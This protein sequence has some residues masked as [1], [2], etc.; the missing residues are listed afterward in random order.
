MNGMKFMKKWHL[1]VSLIFLASIAIAG[2]NHN[3]ATEIGVSDDIDLQL[4]VIYENADIWQVSDEQVGDFC[5]SRDFK[6]YGYAISDL[7]EDGYL[8][9]IKSGWAGPGAL[10]T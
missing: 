1:A 3:T 8:E 2:C 6:N 5:E 4:N 10:F 9:V 7:D